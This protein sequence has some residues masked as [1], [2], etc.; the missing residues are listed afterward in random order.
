MVCVVDD[1]EP[2]AAFKAHRVLG[3]SALPAVVIPV[4]GQQG[5]SVVNV[6]P[7]RN[8]LNMESRIQLVPVQELLQR[9]RAGVARQHPNL[10]MRRGSEQRLQADF[11]LGSFAG[12]AGEC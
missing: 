4:K 8:R 5:Q 1:V 12:L 2:D 9:Q 3:G 6:D 11:G 7:K 10:V